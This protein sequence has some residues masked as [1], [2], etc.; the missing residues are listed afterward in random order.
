MLDRAELSDLERNI[1][2]AVLF[3]PETI[4]DISEMLEA[5]DLTNPL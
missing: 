1:I 5:D 2:E 4:Y 3:M